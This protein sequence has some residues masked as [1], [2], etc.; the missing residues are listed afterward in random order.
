MSDGLCP[1]GEHAAQ[2]GWC[3]DA[4]ERIVEIS[5]DCGNCDKLEA[6]IA[7]LR[8]ACRTCESAI[9]EIMGTDMKTT[10]DW[11]NLRA[12][13]KAAREA[14]DVKGGSDGKRGH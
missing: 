9:S 11:I 2:C 14:L 1:H 12:A 6:D 8:D 5:D 4:I 7:R 13:M 10:T 3:Q